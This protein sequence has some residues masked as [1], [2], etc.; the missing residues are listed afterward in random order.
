V[1]SYEVG[2]KGNIADNRLLWSLSGYAIDWE[3]LQ[4][5]VEL[6]ACGLRFISNF[7]SAKSRGVDLQL[8]AAVMENLRVGLSVAY[9]DGYY[10]ETVIVGTST[11]VDE[12]DPLA[13]AP[14]RISGTVDY[15]FHP[16]ASGE[17]Y[18]HLDGQYSDDYDLRTAVGGDPETDR[19]GNALIASARIGV[20]FGAWD[21]SVFA[22][23]LF[24]ENNVLQANL[25]AGQFIDSVPTPR[26]WGLTARTS[27]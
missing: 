20:R 22:R 8:S 21:V 1:W 27:L 6:S 14:W 18:L 15:T 9:N 11:Q 10:D 3:D 5:A 7:G 19:F 25:A 24:D 26:S 2:A 4:D 12:D 13:I 17:A 23:N 16:F